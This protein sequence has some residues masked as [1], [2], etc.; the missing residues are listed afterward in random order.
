MLIIGLTGT[1]GSGKGYVSELLREYGIFTVDTDAVTHEVYSGGECAREVACA[2]GD[3][4]DESG[5]IDRVKLGG[6]VFADKDKL[7]LLQSIVYKYILARTDE[8]IC[9]R[10]GEGDKAVVID[11]PMLFES[12]FDKRCD[13]IITVTADRDLRL[14]R[15]MKRDGISRERALARMNSQMPDRL[16]EEKAHFVIKNAGE[17]VKAQLERILGELCLI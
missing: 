11:A 9:E 12:G 7:L 15:I 1:T 8:M 4:L 2:L 6:I 16:Y 10:E 17:D 5:A 13:K 3:V 14:E